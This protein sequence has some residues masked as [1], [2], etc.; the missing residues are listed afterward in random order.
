MGCYKVYIN[1]ELMYATFWFVYNAEAGSTPL[2]GLLRLLDKFII[3]LSIACLQFC[4]MYQGIHYGNL[5]IFMSGLFIITDE[6]G[7]FVIPCLRSF[8]LAFLLCPWTVFDSRQGSCCLANCSFVHGSC[9]VQLMWG[10]EV[11]DE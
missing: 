7:L 11:K 6:R 3:R 5:I 10:D 2:F 8:V 1:C 9:K 4:G